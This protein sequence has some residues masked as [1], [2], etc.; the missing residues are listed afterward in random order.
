[1]SGHTIP[2]VV[3]HLDPWNTYKITCIY[4]TKYKIEST[5][6]ISKLRNLPLD[7]ITTYNMQQKC[8]D[9]ECTEVSDLLSGSLNNEEHGCDGCQRNLVL[10]D[11]FS[12]QQL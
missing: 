12:S 6:Y 3:A 10:H 9:K 8:H 5:K 1:M 11:P 2:N 4:T 7:Y